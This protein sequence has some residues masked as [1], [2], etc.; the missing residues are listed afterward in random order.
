MSALVKPESSV[1]VVI[2]IQQRLVD[3]MP[4]DAAGRVTANS[5]RLIQAANT[6]AIPV[7]VTEQYPKGLG[8]TVPELKE[9]LTDTIAIEKTCFS[10]MQS[11]EFNQQMRQAERKQVILVGMESH[12][13]ILQTAIDLHAEGYQVYVVEDAVSSR[14]QKNQDNAM[15]RLSVAGMSI[16]NTESVIF[17]WLGDAK[18]PHFKTL[19]KLIL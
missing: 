8:T 10:C 16:S 5:L 12:I 1:L 15:R 14:T 18:H 19:S 13:C 17:E 3:A 4:D 2:D 6:L 11:T 9:L 7:M